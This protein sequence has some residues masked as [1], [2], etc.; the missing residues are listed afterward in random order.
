M[1][2]GGPGRSGSG[3][4]NYGLAEAPAVRATRETIVREI[5]DF[6]MCGLV[7][8]MK[9]VDWVRESGPAAAKHCHGSQQ[10]ENAGGG[11]RHE[12]QRSG[13]GEGKGPDIL[14][15]SDHR[16]GIKG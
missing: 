15:G 8:R 4:V 13:V 2:G 1:V 11:F 14:A 6:M 5:L 7:C 10:R 12:V 16:I 9:G 3:E